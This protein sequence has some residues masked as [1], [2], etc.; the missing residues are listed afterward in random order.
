M[1][2]RDKQEH[3]YVKKLRSLVRIGALPHD[4]GYHQVSV[5]HDDWCGVFQ[6]QRCN[7]DPDI[8]LKFSLSGHAN[9]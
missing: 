1:P 8:R 2:R 9:N 4:V 7:C 5:Y 3:N 6:G